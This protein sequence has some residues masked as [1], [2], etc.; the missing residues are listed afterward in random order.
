[1]HLCGPFRYWVALC[2]GIL[3]GILAVGCNPLE[4]NPQTAARNPG[5]Y[6]VDPALREFYDTLGGEETIGPAIS[7]LFPYKTR[8]CQYMQNA[9]L[10]R[11]P[12][13]TDV[14]RFGFFP[15]GRT[16]EIQMDPERKAQAGE[17][18]V[19][20]VPIYEE[21]L[22]LYE[23]LYGA[24]YVGRPLSEVRLNY[25]QKRIEQYFE[26]VGFYRRFDEPQGEA[27][28]LA[29]G[30]FACAGDCPFA[31]EDGS[32][33]T[34]I[35]STA[36]VQPFF[37]SL[38]RM[39][40]LTVFGLP[41]SEAYTAVDG[42]MEQIY[43]TAVLYGP[44]DMPSGVRLRPIT[45]ELGMPQAEPV[46]PLYGEADGMV[47]YYVTG[48]LGYHVPIVFDA[49]IASHGGRE[50]S[51]DPIAEVLQADEKLY[52]QCFENYCLDY[53]S[54][55][56]EELRVRMA[57]LGRMILSGEKYTAPPRDDPGSQAAE[58]GVEPLQYSPE[59]VILQLS[60]ARARVRADESNR[61][62]L[63]VLSAESR[64]PL[65]NIEAGVVIDLPD[66]SSITVPI[67]PTDANGY[68]AVDIP[69]MSSVANGVILP[70]HVCLNVPSDVPICA[71]ESFLIWNY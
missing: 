42:S 53:D 2:A 66:G 31:V 57:P 16:F 23:K 18:V 32:F 62:D 59:A 67:G 49:F 26:N 9:L 40:G 51:G 29:Y 43:E 1:M 56:A 60:E 41:L 21:F 20:G 61:I 15:L 17:H 25:E 39:G 28:L 5:T 30:A 58:A 8:E 50:I 68:A 64:Q 14:E 44:A 10:C 13:A 63:L 48:E 34:R 71:V 69:P 46:K 27:H 65:A 45:R 3:L 12:Q 19:D 22:P 11:D 35:E 54:S 24:H 6:T 4:A 37:L 52:R 47:F 33:I 36:A 7:R 70:Y 55:A 38:E